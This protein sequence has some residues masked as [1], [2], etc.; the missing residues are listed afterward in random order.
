MRGE[1]SFEI[2]AS[3]ICKARQAVVT[4]PVQ[5]CDTY[6]SGKWQQLICRHDDGDQGGRTASGEQRTGSLTSFLIRYS[7]F[8]IRFCALYAATAL[9]CRE[10]TSVNSEAMMHSAPAAKKAGR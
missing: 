9:G 5:L 2:G 6:P 7:R 4:P 1:F 10:I 3:L 8:A